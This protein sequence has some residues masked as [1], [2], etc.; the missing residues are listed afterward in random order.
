M[1]DYMIVAAFAS[2][3]DAT[4][5]P[6]ERKRLK[7]LAD[8]SVLRKAYLSAGRSAA[9]LVMCCDGLDDVRD[10]LE[11]LPLYPYMEI[12]EILEVHE[13]SLSTA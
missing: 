12:Q 5:L 9:W 4:L 7:E 11:S 10:A 1:P 3:P 2:E 13:I 6:A 8:G